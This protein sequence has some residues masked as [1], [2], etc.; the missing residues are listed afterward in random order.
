MRW[1]QTSCLL[2]K[3]AKCKIVVVRGDSH[4]ANLCCINQHVHDKVREYW[5]AVSTSPRNNAPHNNHIIVGALSSH[6]M[7]TVLLNSEF[8]RPIKRLITVRLHSKQHLVYRG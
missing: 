6:F 4:K 5:E 2:L 7:H 1:Q 8:A 3:G